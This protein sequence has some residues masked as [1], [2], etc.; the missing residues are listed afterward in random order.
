VKLENG[1]YK[2]EA[3][4][5]LTVSGKHG[6]VFSLDW[7]WIDEETACDNCEPEPIPEWDGENWFINWY[8]EACDGGCAVLRREED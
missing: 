7:D 6:G 1:T 4:A 8:C 5:V 3:G 2:T